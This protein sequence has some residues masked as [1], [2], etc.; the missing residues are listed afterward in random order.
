MK[1]GDESLESSGSGLFNEHHVAHRVKGLAHDADQVQPAGPAMPGHR[2][3]VRL[4]R[5][6][7]AFVQTDDFSP[8]HIV[9]GDLNLLRVVQGGYL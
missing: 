7:A 4:L 1:V 9:D 8:Q 3:G 5:R 2:K 6:E